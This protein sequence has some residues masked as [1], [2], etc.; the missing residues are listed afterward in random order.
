MTGPVI[1]E[2]AINGATSKERNPNSPLAPEEIAA[3]ALAC[4]AAGAA[5]I[6]N[7]IDDFSLTGEVA[8]RRYLAKARRG[9]RKAALTRPSRDGC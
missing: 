4:L 1:I 3:D 6:H 9:E 7:H 5:I 8:A 2:A